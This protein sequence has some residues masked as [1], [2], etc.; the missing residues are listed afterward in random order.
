MRRPE[1]GSDAI[2]SLSGLLNAARALNESL[3]LPHVLG[4]IARE[5]ARVTGADI[6]AVWRG[7]GRE[8]LTL[9]AAEGL[10]PEVIGYRLDPGEGV[11]GRVALSGEP[12]MATDHARIAAPGSPFAGVE[13][14]M[15]VPLS[16]GG[17]LHGVVTVGHRGPQEG[18]DRSLQLFETFAELASVACRNA[19]VHAGVAH[20]ART[21]GLTGCLNHS[22]LHD[23]LQREIERCRRVGHALS[24]VLLD[25]DEFKQVNERHGHLVGDEVLR[26][27][28]HALRQAMRPY[29]HVGRY[30]GDEFAL[31]AVDAAEDEA[32]EIARRTIAQLGTAMDDFEADWPV[33]RARG[34]AAA[35]VAEWNAALGATELLAEA[36]RALLFAKQEGG[37]G[38]VVPGSTVPESFRPRR[39]RRARDRPEGQFEA[40]W[41]TTGPEVDRLRRR[42]RQLALANALAAR[43]A[44]MTD[45]REIVE[46]TVA[47]LQRG[48]GYPVS[49]I[50]RARNDGQ[51]DVVAG[52]HAG[53]RPGD[54]FDDSEFRSAGLVRR[55][56]QEREAVVDDHAIAVPLAGG[57]ELWGVVAVEEL[58]PGVFDDD[59]LRLVRM[60]G[61]QV[62]AALSSALLYERL[63]RAYR[64]ATETQ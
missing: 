41:P 3:D 64:E 14:V 33:D 49:A 48:F 24:L 10:P 34:C 18:S 8:G 29:D 19:S 62:G 15:G 5:A 37:P 30:G 4:E 52:T 42:T 17:R 31:I 28:G 22:A 25:L 9:E 35:G 59:D 7:D 40:E 47:E 1:T 44:A 57:D 27:V 12:T 16:W 60:V 61:E 54:E 56:V 55:A 43:L 20:A 51:V 6:A 45:P 38:S 26:R 50:Y 58:E 46:C 2:E 32:S 63:E 39:F 53:L 11:A 36:D 13:C 23:A 21:D